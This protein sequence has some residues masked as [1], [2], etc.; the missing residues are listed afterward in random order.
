M[1]LFPLVIAVGFILLGAAIV[2]FWPTMDPSFKRMFIG[3][4]AVAVVICIVAVF[5]PLFAGHGMTVTR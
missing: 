3:V 1:N 2:Y 5:W 4:V